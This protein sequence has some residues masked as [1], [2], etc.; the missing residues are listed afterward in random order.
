VVCAYSDDDK[1]AIIIT[2][3]QPHPERWID[4]S[5]RRK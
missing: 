3:Y 5:R 1:L 2:A 4:F